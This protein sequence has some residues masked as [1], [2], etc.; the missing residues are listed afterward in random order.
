MKGPSINRGT[1]K[2][3]RAFFITATPSSE[4]S[5]LNVFLRN[6]LSPN[7]GLSHDT[8]QQSAMQ[9]R[10]GQIISQSTQVQRVTHAEPLTRPSEQKKLY[11]PT[12]TFF[13]CFT[14]ECRST[15]GTGMKLCFYSWPLSLHFTRAKPLCSEH[16]GLLTQ[17]SGS[18]PLSTRPMF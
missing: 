5:A 9:Y 17:P 16:Y 12:G 15:Q 3:R 8:L 4:L 10:P 11:E 6:R 2:R 1:N 13:T 7:R 14:C 18:S